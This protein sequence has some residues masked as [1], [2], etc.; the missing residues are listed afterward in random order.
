[1]SMSVTVTL[2]ADC[3]RSFFCLLVGP[4]S[5]RPRRGMVALIY[6]YRVK[7]G[8]SQL[9]SSANSED[10]LEKLTSSAGFGNKRCRSAITS[11]LIKSQHKYC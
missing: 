6:E 1:M 10:V 7:G 11:Q 4:Q 9:I 3:I 2:F 8:L 5:G